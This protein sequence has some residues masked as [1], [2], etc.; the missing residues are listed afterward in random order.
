MPTADDIL[1]A[2][3]LIAN[4][5][6]SVALT[7]HVLLFVA[8]ATIANGWR[9]EERTAGALAVLPMVSAAVAAVVFRNP[10]NVA[11]LA[12]VTLALL[13]MAV[14]GERQ[15]VARGPGWMKAVG[16][17]TIAY[18]WVYPHFLTNESPAM[19]LLAAPV[20]LLPCPS[21]AAAIGF[22]LRSAR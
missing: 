20:G 17:A 8:L 22:V 16:L 10:F 12:L 19:Y 6:K 9:P 21:I 7:W 18:A 1:D 4:E 13:V 2:L 15:R 3:T 11:L 5:G 14:R